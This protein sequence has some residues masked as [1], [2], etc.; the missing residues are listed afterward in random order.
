MSEDARIP[1]ARIIAIVLIDTEL[2]SLA[3]NIVSQPFDTRRKSPWVRHKL[4][5]WTPLVV[6]PTVVYDDILIPKFV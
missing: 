1:P 2:Q 4:P 5:L 6:Q 3:M